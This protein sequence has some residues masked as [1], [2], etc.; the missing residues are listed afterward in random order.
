MLA[1]ILKSERAANTAIAIVDTFAQVR[2]L[3]RTMEALQ[4]VD[5][6]G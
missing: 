3:A 4:V 6:G 5:D 2:E 1:T